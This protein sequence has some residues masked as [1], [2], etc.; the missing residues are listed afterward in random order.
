MSDGFGV[1]YRLRPAKSIERKMMVEILRRLQH[2]HPLKTYQYIGF[3]SPY[4]SD[5]KL[6]HR[7]LDIEEMIS[8]EEKE[9]YKKRF[10]FNKPYDCIEVKFGRSDQVLPDIDMNKNTI[11]WLDYTTELKPYMFED[12]EEFCYSAPPGS[13]IFITLRAGRMNINELNK[14]SYDTRLDKLKNDVGIDNIPPGVN[15]INLR[16]SWSLA[17]AYRQIILEKIRTDYLVPRNDCL[18][19]EIKF[20]QLANFIYEDS[21][22]MVTIGGI[23]HSQEI[24]E[25]YKKADFDNLDVVKTGKENCHIDPPKLTFAEMRKIEKQLPSSPTQSEV[26]LSDEVKNRYADMYKY[27]PRFVESEM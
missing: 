16:E 2:I 20:Q 23:L 11:L 21:K 12:I 1:N 9:K 22:K 27:F 3:G 13:V 6:F 4:F 5:F 8:I 7:N 24:L 18:D 26:P 25:Q 19:N 14:S 15:D 17:E 10:T